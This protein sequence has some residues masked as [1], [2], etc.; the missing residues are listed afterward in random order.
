MAGARQ[1]SKVKP[2]ATSEQKSRREQ[3]LRN[4][5]TLQGVTLRN[6]VDHD[7]PPTEFQ[8]IKASILRDGVFRADEESIVG[9]TCHQKYKQQNGCVYLDHCSCI[10]DSVE[11]DKGKKFFA[12]GASPNNYGLLRKKFLQ[13]RNPI[14]ECNSKC[15]CDNY[16]KNRVVQHGRK[17]HVEIFKTSDRGWGLRSSE[18]IQLGQFIDTYRGEIITSQEA[19]RRGKSRTQEEIN[20]FFFDFDKFEGHLPENGQAYVCDGRHYGSPARFLNHSCDPNCAIYTVSYNSSDPYIYELAFF[21]IEDIPRGTELT[22]DYYDN[23]EAMHISDAMAR[24]FEQEKGYAPTK[25]LCGSED[26]RGYFLH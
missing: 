3:F 6:D 8:F 17:I 4:L 19:D 16:C 7:S 10:Q 15:D 11:D 22:F 18:D 25:C 5:S 20:N 21:A 1:P 13:T 24:E 26:C 2:G 23:D 12:Y 9:C 14:Y